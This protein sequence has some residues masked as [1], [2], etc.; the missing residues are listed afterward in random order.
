MSWSMAFGCHYSYAVIGSLCPWCFIGTDLNDPMTREAHNDSVA[1]ITMSFYNLQ[2]QIQ[3]LSRM[4]KG[5]GRDKIN[6]CLC[7][8]S[9]RMNGN[10]A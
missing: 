8:F 1:I 9:Y 10:S 2:T 3:A 6:T 5:T 7:Y 4:G